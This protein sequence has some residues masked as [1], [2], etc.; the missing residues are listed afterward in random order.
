MGP[1]TIKRHFQGGR[2]ELGGN[3]A[4][5]E[6]TSLANLLKYNSGPVAQPDRAAVS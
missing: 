1:L 6:T 2:W 5:D 4:N 3:S